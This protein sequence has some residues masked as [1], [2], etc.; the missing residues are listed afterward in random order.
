VQASQAVTTAS[1]R[2]RH[3]ACTN[4]AACDCIDLMNGSHYVDRSERSP[5]KADQS[6]RDVDQPWHEAALIR[7]DAAE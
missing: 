1:Q 6:I 5:E 2:Y 4:G 3:S 7:K